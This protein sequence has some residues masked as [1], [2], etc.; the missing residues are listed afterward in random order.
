[1]QLLRDVDQPAHVIGPVP[2]HLVARPRGDARLLQR[3]DFARRIRLALLAQPLRKL[4]ALARELLEREGVEAVDAAGVAPG[5]AYSVPGV[6]NPKHGRGGLSSWTTSSSGLSPAARSTRLLSG[7]V[8]LRE[9][10]AAIA[11]LY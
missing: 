8:S 10:W 6:P 5:H 4:V 1:M 7:F 9:P 11:R 3:L 2:L